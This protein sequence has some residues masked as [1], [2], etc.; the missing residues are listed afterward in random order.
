[1]HVQLETEKPLLERLLIVNAICRRDVTTNNEPAVGKPFGM[2]IVHN[3][4]PNNLS[5][6][7]SKQ[8]AEVCK[9]LLKRIE[10]TLVEDLESHFYTFNAFI[11]FVFQSSY[12]H[13]SD[14]LFDL[15]ETLISHKTK[16]DK[17]ACR[18]KVLK[19]A[20]KMVTDFYDKSDPIFKT[21]CG[22]YFEPLQS[23]SFFS[24]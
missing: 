7:E 1:M 8:S 6:H 14:L 22:K 5:G 13:S 23:E 24:Y 18:K 9:S 11:P 19:E 16:C 21:T 3:L 20:L 15:F 17:N 10:S 12:V 2:R 4:D